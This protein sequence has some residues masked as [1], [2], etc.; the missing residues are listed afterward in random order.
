MNVHLKDFI[1]KP[2]DVWTVKGQSEVKDSGILQNVD[3]QWVAIKNIRLVKP[4]L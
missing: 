2:V 3:E 1:G 4:T